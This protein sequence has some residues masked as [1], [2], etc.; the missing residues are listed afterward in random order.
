MHGIH[1]EKHVKHQTEQKTRAELF[2]I[3][4]SAH[5]KTLSLYETDL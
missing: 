4:E 1:L 2:Y 3:N 5:R